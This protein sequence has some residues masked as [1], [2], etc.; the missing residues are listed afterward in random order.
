VLQEGL[1]AAVGLSQPHSGDGDG[2][3]AAGLPPRRAPPTAASAAAALFPD[4]LALEEGL[5]AAAAAAVVLRNAAEV[6]QN[7]PL[8]VDPPV[9]RCWTWALDAAREL[10]QQQVGEGDDVAGRRSADDGDGGDDDGGRGVCVGGGTPADI[11][12]SILQV[13]RPALCA[14]SF[15]LFHL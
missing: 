2:A 14:S 11:C 8:L 10:V 13:G 15:F 5:A 7:A 1:S 4:P 6:Q 9:M 3:A 12:T